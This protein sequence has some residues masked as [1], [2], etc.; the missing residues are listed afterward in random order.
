MGARLGGTLDLSA[1]GF[2]TC[3]SDAPESGSELEFKLRLSRTLDPVVGTAKVV[4]RVPSRAACGW[5]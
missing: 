4:G 2:S 5:G 3:V 1:G